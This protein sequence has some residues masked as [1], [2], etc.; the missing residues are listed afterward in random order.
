MITAPIIAHVTRQHTAVIHLT[1]P[2]AEIRR[3]MGPGL[4]ELMSTLAAQG[5]SPAGPWF[6]HHLHAPSDEFDFEISVPVSTPISAT[7][8][9]KPSHLRETE[10]AR[11]TYQGPYEGLSQA[12]GEF[13]QWISANGHKPAEDLWEC[14]VVGPEASTNPADWRTE[15]NRPLV[16]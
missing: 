7:G 12:W 15:L 2:S 1:I 3:V 4:K 5:V 14:Y 9:V 8:R 13:M 16:D 10:V 6:T 11:T